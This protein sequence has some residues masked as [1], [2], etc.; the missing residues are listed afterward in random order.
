M[1]I[2]FILIWVTRESPKDLSDLHAKHLS[3]LNL[4]I[5]RKGRHNFQLLYAYMNH[6]YFV[7]YTTSSGIK[8]I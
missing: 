6:K 7:L 4:F 5:G 2:S 8:I 1:L 3:F